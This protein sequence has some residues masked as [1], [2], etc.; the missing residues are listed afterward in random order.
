MV[1]QA[2]VSTLDAVF[3]GW[4]GSAALAGGVDRVSRWSC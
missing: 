3:V 4:L 2:A 1:L